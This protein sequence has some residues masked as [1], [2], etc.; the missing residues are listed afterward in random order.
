[1]S[2]D[3]EYDPEYGGGVYNPDNCGEVRN[4]MVAEPEPET[5]EYTNNDIRDSL[6]SSQNND[7]SPSNDEGYDYYNG[8]GY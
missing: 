2:S 7:S 8:C 1:M 6:D 4:P 3:Y 5:N